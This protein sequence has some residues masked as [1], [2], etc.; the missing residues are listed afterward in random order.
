MPGWWTLDSDTAV[1]VLEP[2][3]DAAL[4]EYIDNASRYD[5]TRTSPQ[6][7]A[8]IHLMKRDGATVNRISE[9]LGMDA[10]T[11]NAVLARQDHLVTDARMLLKANA[12]G[13]VGDAILASAE[14]AKKG[15]IE[16]I[17]AMLDRLGVTE[18]PKNANQTSVGVQVILN[19]GPA[20]G[21]LSLAKVTETSEGAQNQAQTELGLIIDPMYAKATSPQALSAQQLST[22]EPAATLAHATQPS[23][24]QDV[25]ATYV[26]DSEKQA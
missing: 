6:K 9:I 4:T 11:V 5:G 26:A 18:P 17:S 24:T 8:L 23:N 21:E 3:D 10:R 15:K 14:A 1:A 19:G 7:I 22:P 20:P 25:G 12:L 2:R 13:F 16:G